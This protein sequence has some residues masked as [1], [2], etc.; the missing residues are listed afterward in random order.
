MD[1][2]IADI[3]DLAA[4]HQSPHMDLHSVLSL[5]LH[6]WRSSTH[7]SVGALWFLD[8]PALESL[9]VHGT[10]ANIV[11]AFTSHSHSYLSL[12]TL[13]LASPFKMGYKDLDSTKVREFI[14]LLPNVEKS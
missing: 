11:E 9:V 10:T 3:S 14:R 8:L 2:N 4:T 13:T 6:L 5:D 1:A 12:C 7:P